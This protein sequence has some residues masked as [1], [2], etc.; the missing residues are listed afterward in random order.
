MSLNLT[1]LNF[2]NDYGAA[3]PLAIN[4]TVYITNYVNDT[5]DVINNGVIAKTIT[6]G[7]N[8]KLIRSSPSMPR[9]FYGYGMAYDPHNNLLYVTTESPAI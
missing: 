1:V 5:L 9:M 4:N 7:G 2:T 3:I 8:F 6:L